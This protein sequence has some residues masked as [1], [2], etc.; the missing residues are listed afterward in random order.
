M[1]ASKEIPIIKAGIL[2]K[3]GAQHE[4]LRAPILYVGG[5]LLLDFP[6]K[7]EPPHKEFL[8]WDPNW[9]IFGVFLYVYVLFP[10]LKESAQILSLVTFVWKAAEGG[11][12]QNVSCDFFLGGKRTIECALQNQ[13][14]RPQKVDWCGKCHFL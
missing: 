9:G 13:F 8:G 12:G 3:V 11:G 1:K 7:K 5:S 10:L 4:D 6:G 2:G 14:W